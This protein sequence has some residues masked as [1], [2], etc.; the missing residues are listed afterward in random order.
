MRV[1][2]GAGEFEL[3]VDAVSVRDGSLVL[4]GQMG[5]WESQTFMNAEELAQILR[6]S[7]N[8][9]TVSYLLRRLPSALWRA[10]RQ[11]PDR[12]CLP[13]LDKEPHGPRS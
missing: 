5:V 3:R 13:A 10:L 8:R 11:A 7:L 12:P 1:I 4:S 2:S 9:P 6:T